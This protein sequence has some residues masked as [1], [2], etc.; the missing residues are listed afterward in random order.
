MVL[1]PKFRSEQDHHILQTLAD[2]ILV[3]LELVLVLWVQG[4]VIWI[5]GYEGLIL[6]M[7]MNVVFCSSSHWMGWSWRVLGRLSGGW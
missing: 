7:F 1:A 3:L 2:A 6:N 4:Q 5:V